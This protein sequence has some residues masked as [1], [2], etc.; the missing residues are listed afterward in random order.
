MYYIKREKLEK[1]L[2]TFVCNGSMKNLTETKCKKSDETLCD[3]G[4]KVHVF[5]Y[6]SKMDLKTDLTSNTH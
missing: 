5:I 3:Q 1:S 2:V 4:I 6:E